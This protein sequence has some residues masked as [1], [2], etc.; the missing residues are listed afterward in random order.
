MHR[1]E[2]DEQIVLRDEPGH[3][4]EG[5]EN[6]GARGLAVGEQDA[7]LGGNRAAGGRREEAVDLFGVAR[8]VLEI[9]GRLFVL[10]DAD[11]EGPD[12][13]APARRRGC[14]AAGVE[15]ET[16][17]ALGIGAAAARGQQGGERRGEEGGSGALDHKVSCL[18]RRAR[19]GKSAARSGP[20]ALCS[21]CPQRV[22]GS[23]VVGRVSILRRRYVRGITAVMLGV[24][25]AVGA[26]SIGSRDASAFVWPNVP[27]Q[28]ARALA[29][30]DVS[31]RRARRRSASPSCPPEIATRL[32]AAGHGRS[33][34]R[35][36]PPR[37]AGRDRA[38]HAQGGRSGDHLA[39]RGRRAPPPRRVRRHPRLAH[40]SQR[41]RARPRARRSRRA[42]APRRRG[43]DGQLRRCAEAVSPL[44]GHLDDPSPEVRE[45]VARALGRIGDA[46]AVV[47]LIGKVQDS[48]PDV[49]RV[50][51][52][53]LG[54]LGDRARR[55]RADARAPGRLAR[56][57]PRGRD[58]ARQ[59]PLGRGHAGHRA[60]RRRARARA[61]AQLGPSRGR[62][63]GRRA[64]ARCAR[65]RCARSGAS[66]P[67]RR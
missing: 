27:E 10:G 26:Q 63:S 41:R 5:A 17:R 65:R 38:A 12:A 8:G 21:A 59:A 14:G 58:G 24:A 45:E 49:R 31:E 44:L 57:A 7:A 22:L 28:V 34:R 11:G 67:T 39:Q 60:A 4:A 64:P 33:R 3:L 53:A 47:P 62:R 23:R 51:A 19:A 43:G 42:R 9:E 35:G 36:A 46:R 37:R 55:E 16:A 40:G 56:G 30:G 18:R 52:R 2:D 25:T 66:A 15:D 13:R 48:V 32:V 29:S 6:V 1:E 20:H 61:S 54:E 50:V